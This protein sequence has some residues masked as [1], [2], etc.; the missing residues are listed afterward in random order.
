MRSQ[1]VRAVFGVTA[2]VGVMLLIA[3]APAP[4]QNGGFDVTIRRT[5]HGIPHIE[6]RDYAGIGYGYGYAFAAD[7]LCVV[8]DSYVT[9]SG[10][11]SRFFGP[12]KEWRFQG[13]T[14]LNNNLESDFFFKR[15][16]DDR[17][18]E[19]LIDR[20]APHGPL[21]GFRELVRGYTAGYNRYLRDTGI[22]RLPDPSCRGADWVRPIRQIDVYR[23]IYQIALVASGTA[24][25]EGI[26][27]AQPP[28][29]GPLP[30]GA[31]AAAAPGRA[32]IDAL[33]TEIGSLGVGSNAYGLGREATD[34][35]KGML[36]GNPHFPWDGS[37]RFYQAHM[38]IPGKLDVSGASLYGVPLTLIG[39]TRGLAWSH[40]VSPAFRFTPFELKLVP[41]SPTT[42][43][44]DG[45]ARE[46]ERDKVTVQVRTPDGSLEPRSRTLYSTVYGPMFTSILGQELFPWAQGQGYAMGDVNA[47]N[48]RYLN[49]FLETNLAQSAREYDAIHRRNQGIPFV[50]SIAADATGDAYYADLSV[51]PHVTNEKANECNTA[52]G[53]ALFAAARLPVL[54]GSR[55]SCDWGTDP[56]AIE[57]GIFGPEEHLPSL[58]RNDYVANSNDSY[59]LSNPEQPL[60]GFP[61]IIGDEDTTRSLRTRLGLIQ[62]QQRLAGTDGRPGNRFTLAQL[63]DTV[64]GNRQ[65]AGEL[66]RDRLVELCNSNPVL[67]GSRGPVNVAAACP[68]LAAWE[69]R[70][71]LESRGAILFRT[72]AVD[73][74]AI[75]GGPYS[76]PYSS[77]DPVNTP[78]GLRTEDPRVRQAFADAV[79]E[80]RDRG[81]PLDVPVGT[82]QNEPRGEERIP[83]HGGPGE[84]EPTSTFEIGEFNVILD[85]FSDGDVG[86]DVDYGSSYVQA[87]QFVDGSCPVEPRTILTYSQSS[88]PESPFFADQT[89]MFSDKRWVDVPFCRDDVLAGTR[90]TVR[91]RS[92]VEKRPLRLSVRP[93]RAQRDRR[94]RFSFHVTT[95]A[96]APVRGA[97][98]RFAGRHVRTGRRGRV[99][100]RKRF[101]RAGVRRARATRTGYRPAVARV[102]IVRR[103]RGP[104]RADRTGDSG[105]ARGEQDG[106]AVVRG[107][108][109]G[110]LPFTG[111][112][113]VGILAGGFA[114]LGSGLALRCARRSPHP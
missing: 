84:V 110:E 83:I 65:Y 23:R 62:I 87:V 2:L 57:P 28:P 58:F 78:R 18:V 24:A 97:T 59:W 31:G 16:I 12:E 112:Q 111:L 66:W 100:L 4:A 3:P 50:H 64:F 47:A 33:R 1:A 82:V 19:G 106:V 40:T 79:Q 52:L 94:T 6:A 104:D 17:V 51:V 99:A 107:Q 69:L 49:H 114:L 29:P 30:A 90:S 39:Y 85:F 20:P 103:S 74:L 27:G 108:G 86:A 42:Y 32:E 34:N 5:A 72:F 93:R 38:T 101:D 36:L 43:L 53:R 26:A 105:T 22:D 88:N 9:V 8:A 77:Q 11:R 37:E 73:A 21:M 76:E 54:D 14:S 98:V 10:E 68:V 55:S 81:L 92:A 41:G 95:R 109:D 113:L 15:I 7:N 56:S 35:G 63:Q 89:R 25:I 44:V 102:R 61:L 71:D 60:T 70:S 80:L 46:M 96:G 13:N 67:V 45:Q 91:L 75:P 48:F